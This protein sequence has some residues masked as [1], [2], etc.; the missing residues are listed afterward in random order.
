MGL[1]AF[2]LLCAAVVLRLSPVVI[3]IL[4]RVLYER[5]RRATMVAVLS[6]ARENAGQLLVHHDPTSCD[7]RVVYACPSHPSPALP[8]H[9]TGS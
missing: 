5:A 8:D 4:S 9:A 1:T 3:R 2:T 6:L 7:V